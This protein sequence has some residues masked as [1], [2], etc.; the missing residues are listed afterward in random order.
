M[1]REELQREMSWIRARYSKSTF[2]YRED[3][4]N[5]NVYRISKV[6]TTEQ[7][8]DFLERYNDSF[9]YDVV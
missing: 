9:I 7:E 4:H 1:S 2:M 6:A 3:A 5:Y 8:K